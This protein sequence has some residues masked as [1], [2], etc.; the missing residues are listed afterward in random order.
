MDNKLNVGIAL[1]IFTAAVLALAKMNEEDI[2]AA[3]FFGLAVLVAVLLVSP[4]I[5]LVVLVPVTLLVWFKYYKHVIG[6]FNSLRR[7]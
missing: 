7:G 5:G 1:A 4:L 2:Q 6:F 3:N